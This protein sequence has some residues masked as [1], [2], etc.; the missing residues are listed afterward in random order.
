MY[1]QNAVLAACPVHSLLYPYR[2]VAY[3]ADKCTFVGLFNIEVQNDAAVRIAPSLVGDK[4]SKRISYYARVW[5]ATA[6]HGNPLD[7]LY[8]VRVG[9]DDYVHATGA[10]LVGQPPL[11]F[12]GLALVFQAEM[13]DGHHQVG[14]Q[15]ARRIGF[16]NYRRRVEK[17]NRKLLA[18]R[19][20]QTVG[21]GGVVQEGEFNAANIGDK[22]G[23]LFRRGAIGADVRQPGG[24][25]IVERFHD[26]IPAHI[27][28]MI[29]GGGQEIYTR[30]PQVAGQLGGGIEKGITVVASG[31][32]G[33]AGFEVGN[34]VIRTT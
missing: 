18:G 6:L 32:P 11:V 27:E 21:C 4:V 7:G 28:A 1:R 30:L 5:L 20:R 14:T 9:P 31:G 23:C 34:G 26:S 29:V 25:N 16:G 17:I 8:N 10:Q 24:L 22:R 3:S 33:K 19:D 2:Q 12:A 13:Q 15:L